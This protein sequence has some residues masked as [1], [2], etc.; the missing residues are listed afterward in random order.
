MKQKTNVLI[1]YNSLRSYLLYNQI[2]KNN[3]KLFEYV[4]EIPSTPYSSKT[5]KTNYKKL[6]KTLIESPQFV[7]FQGLIIYL[8]S[9]LSN[10]CN[11]SI[12]DI[13]IKKNIQHIY[14]D[15]FDNNIISF[16]NKNKPSWI[17]SSTSVILSKRFLSI[18]KLGVI[19][20]H[21]APV[22]SY[23]GSAGYIWNLVNDEKE[24]WVSVFYVDE[25]LD[26]GDVIRFGNKIRIDSN[27]SVFTLWL[28]MFNSYNNIWHYIIPFLYKKVKIPSFKQSKT[29][30]ST[31]SYPT[32][33]AMKIL[34]RKKINLLTFNDLLYII[35]VSITGNT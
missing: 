21:E 7:I 8:Y 22:P 16:L 4:I 15:K 27:K 1:Y 17:I 30:I 14:C 29:N 20:F 10:L 34:K 26:S 11:C 23:R 5:K 12:K 3:P 18:P 25:G 13:C 24:T 32:K 9:F 19:N 31:Y 2:L 35:K 33:D 28:K 6:F